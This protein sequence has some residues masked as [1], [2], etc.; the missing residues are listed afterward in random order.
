VFWNLKRFRYNHLVFLVPPWEEIFKGD[1]ERK[2]NFESAKKEFEE[3]LIKY[4]N[5]GYETVLI[6]K[7]AVKERVDF[8]LEKFS[9][10]TDK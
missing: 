5:F 6:P 7:I 9:T 1:A 3:L 2:H 8:I 4:K 10:S